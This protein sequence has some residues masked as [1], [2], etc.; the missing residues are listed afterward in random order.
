MVPAAI[1]ARISS[2]PTGAALGV[3]R[4]LEDCRKL[5]AQR[6]LRVVEEYVDDDR[7]AWSGKVRPA[8]RRMLDD[9]RAGSVGTVLVWHADRLH[10]Q[11]RELEEYIEVCEPRDVPT[12]ACVSG[13]IDLSNPDGRLIARML[14]AVAAHE[15]DSKSRRI[16]RKVLEL[17]MAGEPAG[18]G[19]RPFGY[20]DDRRTIEP[21]GAAAARGAVARVLAGDSLRAVVR[22]LNARG[23]VTSTGG[24]WSIQSLR[25]MLLS[26]RLS[27]QRE[28]RGEIVAVGGWEPIITPEETTRLRALLTDPARLP[29]RTVRSYLLSG[30]LLRCGWCDAVLTSRP[31]E[32]GDRRY[33]CAK[34]PGLPGCGR[35]GVLAEPI[36]ALIAEAVLLR[37][38]TPE[39][40]AALAGVASTNVDAAA[41]GDA[42]ALD[43]HQLDELA[44]AYAERQITLR[45]WLAARAPIEA[46]IVAARRRLGRLTQT[47][48]IEAYVGASA[49]LR[50]TWA[51]LPLNSQRVIVAAV[52]GYAVVRP[53]TPGRTRFDPGRVDPVWRL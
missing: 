44:A 31:T 13:P 32:K 48:A 24:P 49:T 23:I 35:I 12:L 10:R 33:V 28:H 27:G 3:T 26:A 25:R 15:S 38:D 14:G 36:E 4:Q 47:G 16:R 17:A 9:I 43:G 6:E 45:E 18:G 46:R 37:L 53:A 52:L 29:R 8:Y 34:G 21:E 7:S 51:D 20:R 42:L 2:D 22:D 30:G 11:P 41:A 5:A 40:A 1:Y 39:L 19:T 50:A